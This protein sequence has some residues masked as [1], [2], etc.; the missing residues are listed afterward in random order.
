MST[1][2][3]LAKVLPELS[4]NELEVLLVVIGSD[5]PLS[6]KEIFLRLAARGSPQNYSVVGK[7]IRRLVKRGY[8]MVYKQSYYIGPGLVDE[9]LRKINGEEEVFRAQRR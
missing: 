1:R 6:K 5:K 3:T 4:R 8:V 2:E 9:L 7:T